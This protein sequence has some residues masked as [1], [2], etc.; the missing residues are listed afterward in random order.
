MIPMFFEALLIMISVCLCHFKSADKITP[1]NFDSSCFSSETFSIM[2]LAEILPTKNH[3]CSLGNIE[4]EKICLE[5]KIHQ[6]QLIIQATLNFTNSVSS[7]E[8]VI[9]SSA[10]SLDHLCRVKTRVDL[11]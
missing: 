10:Q 3:E 5:P 9:V 6:P 4:R 7:S 11:G 1:R 8:Q 2:M